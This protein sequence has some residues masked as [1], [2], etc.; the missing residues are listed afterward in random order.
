MNK[1][2]QELASAKEFDVILVNDQLDQ[3]ITKAKD[4]VVSFIKK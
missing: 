3:A 2:H 4:M 1:A